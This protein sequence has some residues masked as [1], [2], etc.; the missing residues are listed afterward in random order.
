MHFSRNL[1]AIAILTGPLS[2]VLG[3]LTQIQIT[4]AIQDLTNMVNNAIADANAV[5]VATGDLDTSVRA[6]TTCPL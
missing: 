3:A 6:F 4:D 2:S 5:N 1:Y